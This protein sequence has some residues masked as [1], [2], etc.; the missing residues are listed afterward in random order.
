M[1]DIQ[2]RHEQELDDQPARQPPLGGPRRWMRRAALSLLAGSGLT[3]AG[4]FAGVAFGAE[5][6]PATTGTT[7]TP[8]PPVTATTP[9]AGT[10]EASSGSQQGAA[11]PTN[12]TTTASTPASTTAASPAAAPAPVAG[13][14][15]SGDQATAAP[16]VVVQRKQQTTRGARK[17]GKTDSSTGGGSQ[18]EGQSTAASGAGAAQTAPASVPPGTANG[19]V[20]APQAVGGEAGTLASLLAG[21]AVSAQALA[22]YRVPLFLLPIYQAAAVQ[23]DVPWQILAAINEV[24]TDYGTDL[25]VS[26]AGAVGWMQFMPQ[27]WLMYGVDATDAG[28]ADPYNP[29]DAIFAAARYLHAAGASQNLR[30]AI[31]A[32]NHS[33]AYVESVLLRARLI[34]TYPSSVIGTLTGLVDGR[35]P[36]RG[37]HVAPGAVYVP[38]A[39][40]PTGAGTESGSTAAG[41]TGTGTG[42]AASS[43]TAGAVPASPLAAG[44]TALR[45]PADGAARTA[46]GG[47]DP[48]R[49]ARRAAA[50]V[51]GSTPAPPPQVAAARAEAAANAP[52]KSAQLTDLIGTPGAAVVAVQS[53]RVV[54]LGDSHALGRYLVLR[55]VYGDIFTYAGLGSIAPRYRRPLPPVDPVQHTPGSIAG[56]ASSSSARGTGGTADDPAPTLPASAGRQAPSTLEVKAHAHARAAVAPAS[57]P[58]PE[59][60]SAGMGKVRLY[61]HPDNPLARAVASRAAKSAAVGD[62]RWLPLRSGSLVSQGT[63]LG[64]LA[65]APGTAAGKLRFAVRPAGDNGTIDP[66]A[67]LVNWRQLGAALHPEGSRASAELLG[68][69]ADDV[70]AMSRSEL[71]RSVLSDPGVRLDACGRRDVAAGAIDRRVLAVL[72]FLSRSGLQPTVGALG[73]ARARETEAGFVFEHFASGAVD[74]TAIN[75]VSIAGHQGPGT[76][77]DTTIRALLTL[78]NQFAPHRI[79]SLMEYPQA[80]S[81]R[82]RAADWD[83]IQ[84]GF[85]P[86]AAR[87]RVARTSA[88]QAAS[89]PAALT[90]ELNQTQWDQLITRIAALPQPTVAAK[91]SS[92]AI[93][94]P[95]AASTNRGLGARGPAAGA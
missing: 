64:H 38:G 62:G 88:G 85:G 15:A 11:Q 17:Q 71:E 54:H 65:T 28:Y 63:V 45:T 1:T 47:L 77:T 32:Y 34:A 25:S 58:E 79:F 74:I 95:Q 19:V 27:T 10:P 66:E 82:A 7:E 69:T 36:T 42:S 22:F 91:P 31:L 67:L 16:T 94:D 92:A 73:C 72:E 57:E 12:T 70:F 48:A 2:P 81:T 93:R 56:A 40:S 8:A 3:A 41:A 50:A 33:Q 30:R 13:P 60:A 51:P 75:D 23:Y 4:S 68:A 55:D 59:A 83:R 26:T 43:A 61:A 76:I 44:A 53:G 39:V 49:A 20:P 6:P 24:E 90:G 80:S 35:L 5:A 14:Q 9:Q 21:S 18:G 87:A 46:T 84:I 78:R 89:A 86:V 52:A 37:A 29:V